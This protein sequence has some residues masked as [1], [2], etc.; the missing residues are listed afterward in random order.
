MKC[1][2]SVLLM[3]DIRQGCEAPS[4]APPHFYHPCKLQPSQPLLLSTTQQLISS[5]FGPMDPSYVS[6]DDEASAM[7]AAM[8][9]SAFGTQGPAKKRKFNPK[10]DALTEGDALAAVDKG[11]KKGQGSG[12]NTIP[13]G[14]PRVLGMP[15]GRNEDEIALDLEG[16]E[17]EDAMPDYLDTS[18]APP[19]EEAA[20]MQQ[21][22][23]AILAGLAEPGEE[24]ARETLTQ[25]IPEVQQRTAPRADTHTHQLPE[26]PVWSDR[27][28]ERQKGQRNELWYMGYYDPSF[29]ENPWARLEQDKGLKSLSRWPDRQPTTST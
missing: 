15:C 4:L 5:H 6:S 29:V 26:R 24:E 11:G 12:G 19:A 14:K 22:I 18:Q 23:D 28:P 8:G 1:A 3:I 2:S 21:R 7:A 20:E 9:F 10:T 13:L 16:D 27:G 25:R 17:D